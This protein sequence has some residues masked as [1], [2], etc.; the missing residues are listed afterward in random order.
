MPAVTN[1]DGDNLLVDMKFHGVPG[2]TR[3]T[4]DPVISQDGFL[5]T[6]FIRSNAGVFCRLAGWSLS[7]V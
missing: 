1:G 7:K 5:S 2:P 4:L 6:W 3:D